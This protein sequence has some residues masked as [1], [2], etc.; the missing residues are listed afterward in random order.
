MILLILLLHI[1]D[2]SD[3]NTYCISQVSIRMLINRD[4]QFLLF[5]CKFILVSACQKS[6][7]IECG[8]TVIEKIKGE[9]FATHISILYWDY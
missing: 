1:L 2:Y 8:L 3:M 6:I 7:K 5:C 9:I 4:I